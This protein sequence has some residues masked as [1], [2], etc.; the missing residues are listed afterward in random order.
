MAKSTGFIVNQ[1][2]QMVRKSNKSLYSLLDLVRVVMDEGL[3][4]FVDESL[5]SFLWN[6]V[7]LYPY[8]N[9]L[10]VTVLKIFS[11]ILSS[12]WLNIVNLFLL[13]Y[14]S[15]LL[16]LAKNHLHLLKQFIYSIWKQTR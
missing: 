2:R 5:L 15:H 12:T 9:I 7:L 3:T 13:S 11:S 16:S 14:Q 4:S 1:N 8:N 10:H 6:L